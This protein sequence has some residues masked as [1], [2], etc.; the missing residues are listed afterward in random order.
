M[1]KL[2]FDDSKN[3]EDLYWENL[4][5]LS[6]DK[7]KHLSNSMM[8]KIIAACTENDKGTHYL[9]K[10]LSRNDFKILKMIILSTP[11]KLEKIS[12]YIEKYLILKGVKPLY[13]QDGDKIQMSEVGKSIYDVFNYEGQGKYIVNAKKIIFRECNIL[14]CPYCNI[15]TIKAVELENKVIKEYDLD[16]YFPKSKY[17]YFAMSLYNLIPSCKVCNQTYKKAKDFKVSTHLNPYMDNFGSDCQFNLIPNSDIKL[18]EKILKLVD[19]YYE[20]EN[21]ARK[22]FNEDISH[23]MKLIVER[24]DAN[25]LECRVN[26]FVTDMKII[27]RYDQEKFRIIPLMFI[28]MRKFSKAQYDYY[29]EV[30]ENWNV[31]KTI[32]LNQY[33]GLD[34]ILNKGSIDSK[35]YAKFTWDMQKFVFSLKKD[36]YKNVKDFA[37]LMK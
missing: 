24:T 34:L 20:N 4:N 14:I 10:L 9:F 23:M 13:K 26:N 2:E 5:P 37:D 3:V 36:R 15:G 32:A 6:K 8:M 28:F 19:K 30:L 25:L 11:D 27:D 29:W 22:E 1:N 12:F 17:P 16:H 33:F 31:D 7:K 21:V 35:P 18:V